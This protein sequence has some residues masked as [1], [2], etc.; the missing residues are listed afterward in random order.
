MKKKIILLPLFCF[1]LAIFL[2]PSTLAAISLGGPSPK[3]N[4][5]EKIS[6]DF[7]VYSLTSYEG[8]VELT[9]EC[10]SNIYSFYKEYIEIK[11]N[12][13]ESRTAVYKASPSRT[14]QC[15]IRAKIEDSEGSE[16]E[17][18]TTQE[19]LI[20][21]SVKTDFSIEKTHYMPEETLKIKGTVQKTEGYF[22]GTCT[23]NLLDK[24]YP[25]VVQNNS[26]EK[27]IVLWKDITPGR[28]M[29][30][31]SAA[32][33]EGNIGKKEKE[34]YIE[35]F[36]SLLKFSKNNQT[37]LPGQ[38]LKDTTFLYD[39]VGDEMV[40]SVTVYLISPKKEEI[41]KK[42]MLVEE[43]IIYIFPSNAL[44]GDWT[45]E[46]YSNDLE[47]KKSIYV[48]E[49]EEIST[50]IVNSALR[51][52]NTGNVLYQKQIEII[53]KDGDKSE[54]KIEDISLEANEEIFFELKAPDGDYDIY[55]KTGDAEE[56]FKGIPLTGST[57]KI[58]NLKTRES[59]EKKFI[60][61][62]ILFATLVELAVFSALK[63]RRI[64]QKKEAKANEAIYHGHVQK[65]RERAEFKKQLE[66]KKET[67]ENKHARSW[68]IHD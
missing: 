23:I 65:M 3:Y 38:M 62:L 63:V 35:Q 33:K 54:V 43:E 32:D 40:G 31:V 59:N 26:F 11:P 39:Q 29:I 25:C 6:I 57:I 18:A 5:G 42:V 47:A 37:F 9:L 19:F 28:I 12:V 30:K 10:G 1:L 41:I 46:A 58:D 17:Q 14:G 4:L 24:E 20:T 55:V 45:L 8:F 27:E 7:S 22:D 16:I 53:L 61:I 51:V 66:Q 50:Q 48:G 60:L 15:I 68:W 52:K 2:L 64:S 34:V 44:P 49:R 56:S 36:P 67:K 13:E 21:N